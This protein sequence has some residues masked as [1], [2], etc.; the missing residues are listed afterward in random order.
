M[1]NY[2]KEQLATN[3]IITPAQLH[4]RM[5]TTLKDKFTL[6]GKIKVKWGTTYLLILTI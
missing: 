3:P 4:V 6:A 2:I 5:S 1:D